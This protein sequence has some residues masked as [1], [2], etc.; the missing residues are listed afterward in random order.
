MNSI[1][2]T[3]FEKNRLVQFVERD[4]KFLSWEERAIL[5]KQRF[6]VGRSSHS[7]RKKYLWIQGS[8]KL[9]P[10]QLWELGKNTKKSINLIKSTDW[11]WKSLQA[12]KNINLATS[13]QDC[14]P[15]RCLNHRTKAL[16][17]KMTGFTDKDTIAL[18][19]ILM[20]KWGLLIP[21]R[22]ELNTN[23]LRIEICK[24]R[25]CSASGV[26]FSRGDSNGVRQANSRQPSEAYL[27][28]RQIIHPREV[29]RYLSLWVRCRILSA[30][31]FKWSI[32]RGLDEHDTQGC[33]MMR[34][35]GLRNVPGQNWR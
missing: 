12:G 10:R 11:S 21:P 23:W 7:L 28:W 34:G 29:L 22:L 6:R 20:G 18:A 30:T 31:F 19:I 25:S 5:W 14:A 8:Q 32:R 35:G 9:G 17:L 33:H 2:W 13:P 24:N 4:T 27:T 3:L 16:Q 15:F 26:L 1:S